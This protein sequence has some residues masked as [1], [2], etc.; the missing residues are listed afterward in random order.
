MYSTSFSFHVIAAMLVYK[1]NRSQ[2]YKSVDK[3][4]REK[5]EFEQIRVNH[6]LDN[7]TISSKSMFLQ[8]SLQLGPE[9]LLD[10]FPI[11]SSSIWP[12]VS[13]LF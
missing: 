9:F 7:S 11:Y 1:N 8:D 5:R 12:P 13:L 3:V 10:S 6:Y 2:L 4:Y